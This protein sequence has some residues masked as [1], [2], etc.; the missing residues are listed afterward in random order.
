MTSAFSAL[1]AI[2]AFELLAAAAAA[3][4][5]MLSVPERAVLSRRKDSRIRTT[6]PASA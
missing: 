3:Q 1:G 2:S 4:F 6:S 5:S